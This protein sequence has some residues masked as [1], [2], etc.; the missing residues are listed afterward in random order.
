MLTQPLLIDITGDGITDIVASMYNSTIVAID[1]K[2]FNQLW[3]YSIPNAITDMSPT[4]AYFNSDNITDFL[5]IY[6]KYDDIFNYNYTQVSN[7]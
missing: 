7:T 5:V 2:T 6:Q 4:P 3:N 1:G